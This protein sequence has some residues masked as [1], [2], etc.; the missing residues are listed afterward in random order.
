MFNN[1]VSTR[2]NNNVDWNSVPF[3]VKNTFQRLY[4]LGGL[5]CRALAATRGSNALRGARYATVTA[6]SVQ[7]M[8][9]ARCAN[10]ST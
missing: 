7:L 4:F 6:Q 3:W 1:I 8:L 9:S 10:L 2:R 5:E